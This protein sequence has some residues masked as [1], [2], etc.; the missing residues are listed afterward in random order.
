MI[1][2]LASGYSI[3]SHMSKIALS[4]GQNR[5]QNIRAS[6]DLIRNEIRENVAGK[7]RIVIKPNLC[8][9]N[10]SLAVTHVEA[11]KSLADFL[12][13]EFK[14]PQL[15][16]A[17]GPFGGALK[18]ALTNYG[19]YEVLKNYPISY[20]DLN[21]DNYQEFKLEYAAGKFL[22]LKLA[23][24]ILDSDFIISVCP[25]KTHDSVI[26]TLT[27]KNLLVGSIVT[28]KFPPLV[29]GF[30]RLSIHQGPKKIN[31]ILFE[32]AK[33]IKPDLAIIDGLV[34]M[35]GD[36]PTSRDAV[37]FNLA[38]A[39]LDAVAVDGL[40]TYLMGFNPADVGY[41]FYCGQAGL[42]VSDIEIVGIGEFKSLQKHFK[43][44]FTYQEQLQWK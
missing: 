5:Y 16:I 19:Y 25:P 18:D 23:Q 43:P 14:L 20:V 38:V 15:T 32:L 29:G 13:Q 22:K 28:K 44:H 7:S 24:T 17:E 3:N 37:E 2:A 6:L 35:E 40:T 30:S 12:I 8:V 39:G 36:G 26:V 33:I 41:L 1:Y 21:L 27:L 11:V 34:G 9:K 10:N 4:S 42:G 31:K